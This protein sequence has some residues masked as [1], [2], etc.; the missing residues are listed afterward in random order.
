[1]AHRLAPELVSGFEEIDGQHV[2]LLERLAAASQAVEA[3]SLAATKR[4]LQALGDY[5]LAHFAEEERLMAAAAYPERSRHESAHHLFM[6]DFVQLTREIDA[7]GL[8]LLVVEWIRTRVPEWLK[9][10]MHVND[11][12]LGRYLSA[13]RSRPESQAGS[14]SAK[15]QA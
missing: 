6:Q 2:Q 3:D 7:T 11:I 14:R 1:M 5:L 13:R 8:S 15:P 9:F 10:H 12:P 4:A